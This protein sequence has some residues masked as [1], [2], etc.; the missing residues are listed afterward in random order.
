MVFTNLCILVLWT[1]VASA[2]EGLQ[3]PLEIPNLYPT[4]FYAPTSRHIILDGQAG[5]RSV[6][7]RCSRRKGSEHG[8]VGPSVQGTENGQGR[9]HVLSWLF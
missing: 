4:M 7:I 1:K 3:K 9:K 8:P 5:N 6:R 2:L